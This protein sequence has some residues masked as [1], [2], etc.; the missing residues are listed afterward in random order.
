[1]LRRDSITHSAMPVIRKNKDGGIKTKFYFSFPL[2]FQLLVKSK[3][4][5]SPAIHFEVFSKD[6]WDRILMHGCGYAILPTTP[7]HHTLT[8]S[9]WKPAIDLKTRIS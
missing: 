1:M 7:G 8:A 9:T 3:V 6:Y 2:D 5:E 4:V